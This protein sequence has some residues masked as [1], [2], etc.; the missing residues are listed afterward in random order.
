MHH[1]EDY[2]PTAEDHYAALHSMCSRCH[3]ELHL[4]FR[5]PGRWRAYKQ[6]CRTEG[7]QPAIET[8]NQVYYSVT[9]D[10]PLVLHREGNAWWELLDTVRYTGPLL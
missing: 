8:M 4:R 3:T 7:A 6:K 2:G 10:I 9:A 5:F 1:A